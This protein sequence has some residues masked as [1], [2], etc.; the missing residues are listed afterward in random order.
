MLHANHA[1][2]SD[3]RAWSIPIRQNRVLPHPSRLRGTASCKSRPAQST[4]SSACMLFTTPLGQQT[5]RENDQQIVEIASI[6][7]YGSINFNE[8]SWRR[9]SAIHAV[10]SS[11]IR[12]HPAWPADLPR[13]RPAKEF[14]QVLGFPRNHERVPRASFEGLRVRSF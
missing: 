2:C 11:D 5:Y 13:A 12:H 14:C 8:I 9:I 3:S 1:V 6:C 7:D 10:V 4:P